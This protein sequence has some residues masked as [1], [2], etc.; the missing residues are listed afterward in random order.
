MI[1]V[2]LLY[3]ALVTYKFFGALISLPLRSYIEK[4]LWP[5]TP[6]NRR[7]VIYDQLKPAYAKYYR[8]HEARAL[9]EDAGFVNVNLHNRHGYS[10]SVIGEKPAASPSRYP[11]D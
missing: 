8:Q 1:V 3:G 5:M 2:W 7:L 9:L 10:W 11:Q 4:V 6:A